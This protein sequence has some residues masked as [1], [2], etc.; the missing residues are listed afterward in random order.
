[1]FGLYMQELNKGK[2]FYDKIN[3]IGMYEKDSLFCF[4]INGNSLPFESITFN[5][6][7]YNTYNANL[8]LITAKKIQKYL[9]KNINSLIITEVNKKIVFLSKFLNM[10]LIIEATAILSKAIDVMDENY[11]VENFIN[12]LTVIENIDLYQDKYQEFF[13]IIAGGS[14]SPLVDFLDPLI[15]I[16]K[17]KLSKNGVDVDSFFDIFWEYVEAKHN[18]TDY[19]LEFS[20][21]DVDYTFNITSLKE[22]VDISLKYFI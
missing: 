22:L 21:E 8:D 14:S 10:T 18:G 16:L 2:I 7:L 17:N 1:M 11:S 20:F 3:Q 12:I 19:V 4:T 6:I 5:N 13:D 15:L 9:A